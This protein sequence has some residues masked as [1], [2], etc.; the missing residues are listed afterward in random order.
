MG[1]AMRREDSAAFCEGTGK[2]WL[3]FDLDPD[4]PHDRNA[5]K[6]WGC[7]NSWIGKRR[8]LLGFV[9]KEEAAKMARL[10]VSSMIQPRL[11]KTYVGRDGFVEIQFQ[12]IGPS[13]HAPAYKAG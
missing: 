12:I 9:D 7:W 10:G 5:I 4:N 3:E 1:T 13:E 11:L 6:V 2:Q 8:K